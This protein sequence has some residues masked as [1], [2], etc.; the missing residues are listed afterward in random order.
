[1][2]YDDCKKQY[3]QDSDEVLD[4]PF[5][6][7]LLVIAEGTLNRTPDPERDHNESELGYDD[8]QIYIEEIGWVKC[9]PYTVIAK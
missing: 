7:G 8:Y 6:D 2:W 1:M 4:C 5:Y 3:V 9:D